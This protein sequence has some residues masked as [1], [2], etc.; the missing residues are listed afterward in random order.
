MMYTTLST[1]DDWYSYDHDRG[2]VLSPEHTINMSY[3]NFWK[4][5][6]ASVKKCKSEGIEYTVTQTTRKEWHE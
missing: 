3:E 2:V 4:T 5:L 6:K 1:E